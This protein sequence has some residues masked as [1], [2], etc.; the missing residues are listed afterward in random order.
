MLTWWVDG[1]CHRWTSWWLLCRIRSRWWWS[2]RLSSSFLLFGVFSFSSCP[3]VFFPVGLWGEPWMGRCGWCWSW[4]SF[5]SDDDWS[6]WSDMP[7]GR[8]VP[9]WC[10]SSASA[11][12][13][14]V[15][16]GPSA[17]SGDD[18]VAVGVR[19]WDRCMPSEFV[20]IGLVNVWHGGQCQVGCTSRHTN[21][22]TV[23]CVA[24]GKTCVEF[25]LHP[26]SKGP[27]FCVEPI[28]CM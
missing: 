11:R 5:G 24:G 15:E 18:H 9:A 8:V 2:F 23:E 12:L 14:I 1:G 25:M 3:G 20:V 28:G 19:V 4:W 22:V 21:Q 16:V 17:G 6:R 26:P 7:L 10:G 13:F 27:K